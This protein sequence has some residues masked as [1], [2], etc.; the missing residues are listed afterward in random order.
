MKLFISG[1]ID[2][3]KPEDKIAEKL[4]N[5]RNEIEPKIISVIAKKSYGTRLDEI[6]LAPMIMQSPNKWFDL[7]KERK[8]IKHKEKCADYRLMID[9]N[10]FN[11]E[12]DEGRKKLLLKNIIDAIIMI[13]IKLKKDFDGETLIRDIL[14]IWG[15][16]EKEIT[17][18]R[19]SENK[20]SVRKA[21][22]IL[23]ECS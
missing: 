7:H 23:G 13:S 1:E 12:S 8:L 18:I 15:Y 3:T 19:Y 20:S 11:N 2:G 9:Y 16:E 22:P 17:Q 4:R 21:S 6:F 14:N 10:A 5:A